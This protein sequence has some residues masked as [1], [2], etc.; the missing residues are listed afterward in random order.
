LVAGQEHGLDATL[1]HGLVWSEEHGLV[2]GLDT[3]EEENL[4]LGLVHGP[5]VS[6]VVSE[7]VTFDVSLDFCLVR[8]EADTLREALERPRALTCP[9]T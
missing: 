8:G 4:V 2:V 1:V 3:G 7:V 9:G 6:F 5:D